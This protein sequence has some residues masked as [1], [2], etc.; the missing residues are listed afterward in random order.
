MN[1]ILSPEQ[2]EYL[3]T[4]KGKKKKRK[5]IL[6]CI[7]EQVEGERKVSFKD[8]IDKRQMDGISFFL[9]QLEHIKPSEEEKTP[10]NETFLGKCIKTCDSLE[11]I[12][13][14]KE[15]FVQAAEYDLAAM[16]RYREKELE[17]QK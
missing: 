16:C 2:Q 8:F 1:L 11:A 7:I 15:K 4:L 5:F 3:K 14:F 6:D 13:Y 10:P 9:T 12:K 17:K